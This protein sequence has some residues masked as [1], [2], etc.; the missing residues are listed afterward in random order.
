MTKKRELAFRLGRWISG[1]EFMKVFKSE[2]S[3]EKKVT[4]W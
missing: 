2:S 1:K 4:E 3:A